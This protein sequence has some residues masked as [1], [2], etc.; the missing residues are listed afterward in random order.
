MKSEKV[1]SVKDNINR[2]SNKTQ[3]KFYEIKEGEEFV[4]SNNNQFN[5]TIN[6]RYIPN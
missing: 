5:S 2:D 1:F 6:S 4:G 3:P